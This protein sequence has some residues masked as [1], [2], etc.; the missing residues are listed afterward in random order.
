MIKAAIIASCLLLAAVPASF[1]QNEINTAT[2]E[3]V[4]RQA[5]IIL[6][7]E[8]LIAANAALARNDLQNAAKLYDG[9][10]ELITS[11]GPGVEPEA[12]QTKSGIAAARLPLATAAQRRGDYR[13]ARRTQCC[14]GATPRSQDTQGDGRCRPVGRACPLPRETRT[15]RG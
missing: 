10:W 5:N 15:S 3:A 2:D 13:E 11:I 4:R 6:L 1:S 9:A 12:A 8:K 14:G 7:R